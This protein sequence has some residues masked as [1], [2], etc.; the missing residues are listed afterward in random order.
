MSRAPSAGL[1]SLT[2][3][4]LAITGF[5]VRNSATLQIGDEL[6]TYTGVRQE[7]P[8]GFTGCQR[9]ACGTRGAAHAPGTP[10]HHLKECFGLFVP[11]PESSLLAEVAERT[12]AAFNECGFDMIY[13]DALDGEDVLGGAEHGWHY[14]SRFV[15]E[16]WKRLKRPALMER[17]RALGI[18]EAV[19]FPGYVS[20][21]ASILNETDLMVLPSHTEG[22]PNA[23]LEAMLHGRARRF[24]T[25][26][27]SPVMVQVLYPGARLAPTGR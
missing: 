3:A 23:A 27:G 6:L 11:D 17:S 1:P 18:Q 19:H 5:F 24:S 12:A 20:Q 21:P 25:V 14:G 7:P 9:G 2:A 15:Y 4:G 13:L 22:L 16:I 10:V 8:Y 26:V